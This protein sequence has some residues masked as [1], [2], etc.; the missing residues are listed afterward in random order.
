M[1]VSL[2]TEYALRALR[3]LGA[4][5]NDKSMKTADI[6]SQAGVPEKYLEAILVDLRKAGLLRSRRGPEG[7]HGLARPAS[8]MTVTEVLEAI[9]GPLALG[10]DRKGR[11]VEPDDETADCVHEIWRDVAA[12]IRRE[13]DRVTIAELVER[14]ELRRGVLH[15]DI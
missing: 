11:A 1:R 2:R 13:L 10:S 7:G 6:A 14:V 5:G 8:T 4:P 15:F 3:V 9:D 12:A